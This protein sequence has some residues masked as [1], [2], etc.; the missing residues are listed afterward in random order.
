MPYPPEHREQTKARI[1]RAARVLFNRHGFENV[2]I[3]DVMEHA[4]LTRGGFYRHFRSKSALYAE[5]ITLSLA[6]TPWS[7]WDG[8]SV[9]FSADDAARQV[10]LAY[11]SRQHLGDVDNSCPTIALPS[12]VARSEP[13]V[14][15]AFERVFTSMVALFETSLRRQGRSHRKR[16]LAIAG[17]CVGGMVVARA[18]EDPVLA[19]RLRAAS[20]EVALDLGGWSSRR[21]AAHKRRRS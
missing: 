12:E 16:A 5:A 1:L 9:D 21:P 7:H 18:V 20:K 13:S 15:R 6:D 4:K 10:V 19:D 11:L 17:L 14:K 3:D 8:V 2:S